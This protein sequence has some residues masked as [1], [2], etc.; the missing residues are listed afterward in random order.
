M[1]TAVKRETEGGLL[2]L[3]GRFDQDSDLAEFIESL[4]EEEVHTNQFVD[5]V[6]AAIEALQIAAD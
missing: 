6:E 4:K 3:G 2:E 1:L 5:G